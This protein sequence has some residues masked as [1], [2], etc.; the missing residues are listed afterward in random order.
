MFNVV[1]V[2]I[3]SINSNLTLL[4]QDLLCELQT[5]DEQVES[6]LQHLCVMASIESSFS[7][8]SL[9]VDGIQ[10]QDKVKNTHQLFS[11]VEEQHERNMQALDR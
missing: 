9:S 3:D 10:L 7:L 1:T 6:L 11:E 4:F 8:E 2:D 5:Q